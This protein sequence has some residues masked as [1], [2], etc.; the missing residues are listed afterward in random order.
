MSHNGA[1]EIRR[2]ALYEQHRAAGGRLVP[3]AGWEMPIQYH[4][5][6][7]EHKAVRERAGLFDVSHMGEIVLSGPDREK[8]VD[9]LTTSHVEG[10]GPGE[11]QYALLLKEDG[12]IIDDV[13]VY[14]QTDT[15]LI[16]VNAANHDK[17]L[18]WIESRCQGKA[19]VRD[20][21]YATTQIALQ[22]PKSRK[23]LAKVAGEEAV[24]LGYYRSVPSKVAGSDALVSRTGYTGE[25]G[26]EI[27]LHWEDGPNV[28]DALM[29][30]GR[31]AGISPVGLGAR[32]SLRLEM[33]YHLYG[34]DITEETNPVEAGLGWVVRKKET[35]YV[36]REAVLAA[37]RD[38]V[39]RKLL[40]FRLG[41]REI[42]R[43]G[44]PILHA[45][46]TVGSVTSGGFSPTLGA[47]I[48]LGYV[49]R[50]AAKEK[51]GFAVSI[52]NREK[53]ADLVK[54]PFVPS[55]VK[56]EGED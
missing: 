29:D 2:T 10:K 20:E 21:S 52:R 9:W 18:A 42:P 28:W 54:G 47:G 3:F 13:L 55:S 7:E 16:V 32:D 43:P 6:I 11:V 34:N 24:R 36:G 8:T 48:A 14:V 15:V 46:R 12:G 19:V 17:D 41:P 25:L 44:Y 51:D 23:I 27:Y 50:G 31:D 49:E 35:D 1:T 56:E 22:G 4:S 30:A 5:M 37:R 38:G 53:A 39:G 40:G 26:Y 45:G 33:R